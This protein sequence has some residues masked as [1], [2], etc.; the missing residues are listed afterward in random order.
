MTGSTP[1]GNTVDI[2]KE[3]RFAV[4]LYGGVSL[5]VYIGGITQEMLAMVRATALED[6][7]PG[8]RTDFVEKAPTGSVAVYRRLAELLSRN[9][10]QPPGT[11]YTRFVVDVISGTSAGGL[12]GV[13]L[14]KALARA[15]TLDHL[16]GLWLSVGDIVGLLNTKDTLP[17]SVLD[18]QH[19]FSE[20]HKAFVSMEAQ[21]MRPDRPEL[22]LVDDV[23]CFATTTDL[24]GL[25]IAIRLAD[26]Q[27]V[28]P[29]NKHVY[30]FE[31]SN[32]VYRSARNDFT[33]GDNPSLALASRS[34]SAFPGAFAPLSPA[35][36]DG[37]RLASLYPAYT[38]T[39]DPRSGGTVFDARMHAFAD[40]GI[41][42]NK[43]F[44]HAIGALTSRRG[45][46]PSER[47]LIYV[48]PSPAARVDLAKA[49]EDPT[50]DLSK[51][52]FLT[53][54][55]SSFALPSQQTIREDLERV[56]ERNRTIDRMNGIL[57]D[58]PNEI[59]DHHLLV[60]QE[61]ATVVD[62]APNSD[63]AK[64]ANMLLSIVE[65][66]SA[67]D[68]AKAFATADV[69][70][71]LGIFGLGYGGYHRLKVA[72]VTDDMSR[73]VARLTGIDDQSDEFMAI[74]ALVRAWRDLRFAPYTHDLPPAEVARRD[75]I[76]RVLAK[77]GA[78]AAGR[79][80]RRES[81]NVFL[82]E[83]DLR[84]RLRR[85]DFALNKIDDLFCL[86][87][88][89][90][91]LLRSFGV[92]DAVAWMT[93]DRR[94]ELEAMARVLGTA[95]AMLRARAETLDS[96]DGDRTFSV[97]EWVERMRKR[98]PDIQ[99]AASPAPAPSDAL[100][101]AIEDLGITPAALRTLLEP[102]EATRN[103][104]AIE[105]VVKRFAE[106]DHVAGRIAAR[107]REASILSSNWV[108]A[109]LPPPAEARERRAA[110]VGV[111]AGDIIR[112]F[113]DNYES[114]DRITFPV[115]YQTAVGEETDTV[116]VLRISPEDAIAIVPEAPVGVPRRML[117]GE[118]LGH[119]GG[120][121]A[122]SWRA[123]DFLWGQL[124]G[125][126][127]LITAACL[128]ASN[129]TDDVRT[130]LIRDAQIAILS[131]D[132]NVADLPALANKS[133]RERYDYLAQH[134]ADLLKQG[135]GFEQTF[136]NA[137]SG[138]LPI[139]GRIFKRGEAG[140]LGTVG[141]KIANGLVYLA[142][143]ALDEGKARVVASIA[144]FM[145]TAGVVAA[146]FGIVARNPAWSV[147]LAAP[148][149]AFAVPGCLIGGA[150]LAGAGAGLLWVRRKIAALFDKLRTQ[151]G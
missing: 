129:I 94:S 37:A 125:A 58:V 27:V 54:V 70:D 17:R 124:D 103:R 100:V 73:T 119:F 96:V 43:P 66:T 80:G 38:G 4:V 26:K 2:R 77:E 92:T 126:E 91:A 15:Q 20:L 34:T 139:L 12:N 114:I 149:R 148:I 112:F 99:V 133:G 105:I 56:L 143:S 85:L 150:V 42:N 19:M 107:I 30:Q 151:V 104:K 25:P 23:V 136:V 62:N 88:R 78:I 108:G 11:A 115:F 49:R 52:G 137:L 141:G 140:R 39:V 61:L 59:V 127:R 71:M 6:G 101:K 67:A 35:D 117:G 131:D 106:F 89:G 134:H 55:Q 135:S 21:A 44:A 41:L 69:G 18:G 16:R 31:F 28:E 36:I 81:E 120:F 146:V 75:E 60:V 1:T 50:T 98:A 33:E 87:D 83:W 7:N 102:S 48:E 24:R 9:P 76:E 93:A 79:T 111:R 97:A 74:R 142:E 53:V 84:Y 47:R 5:A 138:A 82:F 90:T 46:K 116:A 109:V 68:A 144:W 22:S 123:N 121:F 95:Y 32:D 128:G 29:R 13:F 63:A 3:I 86:D 147:W 113:Y 65:P 51:P 130:G 57:A 40:G 118:S 132:A 45:G 14:A 110:T 72:S 8:A 10:D 145:I 122:R 64:R